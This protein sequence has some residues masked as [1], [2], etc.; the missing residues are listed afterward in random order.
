MEIKSNPRGKA[1]IDTSELDNFRDK[2]LL[3]VKEAK[4]RYEAGAGVNNSELEQA[5]MSAIETIERSLKNKNLTSEDLEEKYRNYQEQ[6]NSL[7][8]VWK[9]RSLRDKITTFI[10]RQQVSDR[11]IKI[12]EFGEEIS[13][14]E[15][16]KGEKDGSQQ[17]KNNQ[18]KSRGKDKFPEKQD[19]EGGIYQ[20]NE[21]NIELDNWDN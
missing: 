2:M 18:K 12:N 20:P 9:V 8:K 1:G 15:V 3:A 10:R 4:E 5:K 14:N 7:D 21:P 6:I 19:T 17:P 16:G 11:G 13:E